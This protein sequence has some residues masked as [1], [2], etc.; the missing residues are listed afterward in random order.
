MCSAEVVCRGCLQRLV[1]ICLK[2]SGK[3]LTCWTKLQAPNCAF[4]AHLGQMYPL[5]RSICHWAPPPI[6]VPATHNAL[7]FFIK[8]FWTTL[9][10]SLPD[11][12]LLCLQ[13]LLKCH[14][15]LLAKA[16]SALSPRSI[17]C[18]PRLVPPKL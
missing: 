4:Q 12:L 5:S 7:L 18:T 3:T 10:L 2:A 13:D 16:E 9:P 17:H 11:K 1:N 14:H 15:L 6:L 8:F